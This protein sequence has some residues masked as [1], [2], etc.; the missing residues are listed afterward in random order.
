[1]KHYSS[2][3]LTLHIVPAKRN[4]DNAYG[5]Y[6]VVS[7]TFF[8]DSTLTYD[9]WEAVYPVISFNNESWYALDNGVVHNTWAETVDWAKTFTS[10]IEVQ[11]NSDAGLNV[12]S[13]TA[14]WYLYVTR[15]SGNSAIQSEIKS[16]SSG[17]AFG[18]SSCHNLMLR[19]NDTTQ[20]TVGTDG[21]VVLNTDV[22]SNSN[23]NQVATTKWVN[24]KWYAQSCDIACIN[25]CCLTNGW[26]ICIQGWGWIDNLPWSPVC[27]CYKWTGDMCAY[28]A[29]GTYRTD[30]E[31]NV[32]E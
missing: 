26:D 1:M 3:V 28:C 8:T 11:V 18:T 10:P 24:D 23:N 22:A 31:Y 16:V 30:T 4:S 5:F 14:W 7:D 29:L 6:D 32:Y 13:N 27:I 25:W 21:S 9:V 12:K 17:W 19:T 2:N 20:V 15:W